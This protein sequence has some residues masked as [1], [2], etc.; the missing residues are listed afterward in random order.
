MSTPTPLHFPDPALA[1]DPRRLRRQ[2]RLPNLP[3]VDD[4]GAR[5]RFYDDVVRDRQ[6]VLHAIYSACASYC[7]P[8]TRN[9]LQARQLLGAEYADLRVVSLTLTPV[10]DDPQALAAYRR[11][12]G[13]PDS[14]LLLTGQPRHL[15]PLCRALGFLPPEGSGLGLDYHAT[16]GLV[17]DEPLVKWSHLSTLQPPAAIARMV[18]FGLA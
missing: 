8:S 6:V 14:W 2:N 3:V 13:L 1:R 5:L 18:R 17:G 7:P 11:Q 10:A 9:L 12:Y 4:R 16:S 15:E